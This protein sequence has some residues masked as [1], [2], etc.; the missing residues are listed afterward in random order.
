MERG[1]LYS[2]GKLSKEANIK[3]KTTL[4]KLQLI[5]QLEEEDK[6]AL[7]RII[8]TMLIESKSKDIFQKNIAVLKWF[9]TIKNNKAQQR[10]GL[11]MNSANWTFT[12]TRLLVVGTP[13]RAW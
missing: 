11:L 4:E 1:I 5:E 13:L 6:Q 8:D 12:F 2:E 7:F 3:E 10:R 9:N